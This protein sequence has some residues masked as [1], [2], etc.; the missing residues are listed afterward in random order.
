MLTHGF[1]PFL[2]MCMPTSSARASPAT[3]LPVRHA[4]TLEKEILNQAVTVCHIVLLPTRES[5][6]NRDGRARFQ[7]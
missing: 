5:H 7:P 6:S 4:M 3:T 2:K 1:G